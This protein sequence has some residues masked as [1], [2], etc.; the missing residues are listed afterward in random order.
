MVTITFSGNTITRTQNGVT[1]TFTYN[2][3][4]YDY[5]ATPGWFLIK[6][7]DVVLYRGFADGVTVSGQ[8]TAANIN[9]AL[10]TYVASQNPTNI[11]VLSADAAGIGSTTYADVPGLV[12]PVEI[13]TYEFEYRL[14]Y[15]VPATTTGASF[16][17]NGSAFSMLAYNVDFMG[18]SASGRTLRALN[19][20]DT[21]A[22]P[23]SSTNTS[24]MAIVAGIVTFTAAGNLSARAL[25]EVLNSNVV[26]KA[27]ASV[28]W[29]RLV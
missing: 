10:A 13:G 4:R 16:S 8:T 17:L 19:A 27:G 14:P 3:F 5:D 9:T 23:T 24:G 21:G 12:V 2:N 7:G 20:Y 1:E 28:R 25:T 11:L 22:A 26:I 18:T 6:N 15:T 29:R